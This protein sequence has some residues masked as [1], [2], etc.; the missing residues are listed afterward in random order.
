MALKKLAYEINPFKEFPEIKV[1]KENKEDA[2]AE[3][4]SFI[5]EKVL[6][7]VGDGKSPVSGESWKRTLSKEYLKKKNDLSSAGFANMELTGQMLDALQVVPLN[8]EKVS[9]QITGPQAPKADGHNNFSGDS[10]LPRRRFIPGKD[11]EL[12]SDIK[13]G[14]KK[15]LE[16]YSEE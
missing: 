2:Q 5:L 14:I 7:Y 12:K 4:R 15:I 16:R 6:D 11:Q 1:P 3:I 8:S 13:E 9:L 10:S